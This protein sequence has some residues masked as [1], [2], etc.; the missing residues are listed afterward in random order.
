MKRNFFFNNKNLLLDFHGPI[1][2]P[3]YIE[4]MIYYISFHLSGKP[5]AGDIKRRSAA[6]PPLG[7]QFHYKFPQSDLLERIII[8]YH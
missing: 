5:A 4:L 3:V 1:S 2:L 6:T 8:A 7:G